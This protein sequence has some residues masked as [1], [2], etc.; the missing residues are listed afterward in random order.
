MNSSLVTKNVGQCIHYIS[1]KYILLFYRQ[2]IL[3]TT[4]ANFI[5]AIKEM[6]DL[7]DQIIRVQICPV[8]TMTVVPLSQCKIIL[9]TFIFIFFYKKFNFDLNRKS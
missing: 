3:K 7:S 4:N 2:F 8:G 6:S 9:N 5:D 1:S